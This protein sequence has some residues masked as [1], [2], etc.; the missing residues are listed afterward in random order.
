MPS[1]E[2]LSL[3]DSH[4]T[5]YRVANLTDYVGIVLPHGNCSVGS[6]DR[7]RDALCVRRAG[8]YMTWAMALCCR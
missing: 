5:A 7:I 2:M 1:P 8:A 3:P 4:M 6:A